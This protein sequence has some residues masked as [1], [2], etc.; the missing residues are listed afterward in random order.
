M[1]PSYPSP[2]HESLQDPGARRI[3]AVWIACLVLAYT[4][5]AQY[6]AGPRLEQLVNENAEY[7]QFSSQEVLLTFMRVGVL[8]W[9]VVAS[10]LQ[11]LAL[12]LIYKFIVG[13]QVPTLRTSWFWVL[14]GQIPFML[15]VLF[16]GLFLESE[17]TLVLG[18]GWLRILFG[19]I[20]AALYA[21]LARR[22][23][24]A[25]SGRLAVLFV[26]SAIINS[27]LLVA[28]TS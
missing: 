14:L 6:A 8:L 18:Q 22:L 7:N 12:R 20:A 26:I 16:V 27:A 3:N 13:R 17:A 28:G 23:F 4:A 24:G 15:T 19:A 10:F 1:T 9:S 11:A 2:S 5:A 25:P 21:V